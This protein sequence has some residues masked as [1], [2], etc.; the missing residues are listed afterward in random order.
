MKKPYQ[1]EAQRAV[2]Q[3]EAMAGDGNPAVQM[4]LPMAEMVGWLRKGVGE[5]EEAAGNDEG[6]IGFVAGGF[7]DALILLESTFPGIR[8]GLHSTRRKSLLCLT[9]PSKNP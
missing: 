6:E 8:A 2:K 1:I 4:V 7:C 5:A 3:L 9:N